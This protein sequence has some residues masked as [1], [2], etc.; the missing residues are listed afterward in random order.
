MQQLLNWTRRL[1]C[2]TVLLI[3]VFVAPGAMADSTSYTIHF[4]GFQTL[5]TA[6]SVTYDSDLANPFSAFLVTW[7][8]FTFD[9]TS[10]ANDPLILPDG[11]SCPLS[12]TTGAA[13]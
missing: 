1:V 6:G 5:P 7:N 2:S 9:L 12:G 11:E 13:A 3:P 8:G 10:S 4:I